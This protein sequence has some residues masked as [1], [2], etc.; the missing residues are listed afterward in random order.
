MGIAERDDIGEK[1]K[2]AKRTTAAKSFGLTD[3]VI[4]GSI[5]G[6]RPGRMR[7]Q[8]VYFRG[9]EVYL[10]CYNANP[11]AMED[12]FRYFDKRYWGEKTYVLG[13][14]GELGEFSE[15]YHREL[16]EYFCN[17]KCNNFRN[18]DGNASFL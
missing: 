8:T 9:Y 5:L 10:D 17:K 12:A 7:G 1:E 15:E 4:Q 16:A 3:A 14:T 6:W 2:C 18:R 11:V 13:W